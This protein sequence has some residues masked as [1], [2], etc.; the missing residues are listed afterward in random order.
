MSAQGYLRRRIWRVESLSA[1][2][3]SGARARLTNPSSQVRVRF[4]LRRAGPAGRRP[5]QRERRAAVR[6]P[7]VG[8]SHPG[9]GGRRF[10]DFR[11]WPER[12]AGTGRAAPPA[13][14]SGA[15]GVV[16]HT[17]ADVG[18]GAHA[19]ATAKKNP[20]TMVFPDPE[21]PPAGSTETT[22]FLRSTITCSTCSTRRTR[23]CI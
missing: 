11:L 4:P 10:E 20:P 7:L 3:R 12:V 17:R 18:R 13:C 9:R 15:G 19:G 8:R 5:R 2:L 16:A 6:R 23:I 1:R 21:A 22:K 14:R